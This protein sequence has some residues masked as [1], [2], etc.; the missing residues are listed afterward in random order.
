MAGSDY[1]ANFTALTLDGVFFFF[2]MT[3]IS[4]DAVLPLFLNRLGAS[5]IAIAAL[6]VAVVVGVN[7]P[8][9]F[10]AGHL[11]RLERKLPYV[12]TGGVAQRVPWMVAG[13]LVPFLAVDNPSV[14]TAAV[15]CAVLFSTMAA[16]LVIPGF[17]DIL[18][19]TIPVDRRGTLVALRSI[20]SY[21]AGI[22]GGF[23]VTTVL[24]NI[25]YPINY[26]V[27][28]GIATVLLFAGLY[29]MSRV[30][31]PHRAVEAGERRSVAQ[32]IRF[33]LG[34]SASFRWY[35]VM[36]SI[37]VISFATTG[38]FPVYLADSFGLS[39]SAAGLFTV[40]TAVTFVLVNPAFG[41]IG[42]RVGYKLLF[43]ISFAGLIGASVIG[44]TQAS[45]PTAYLLVV[46]ASISR[47]VN[48]LSFNMTVEF[49]PPGRVPSFIGV[50]GLFMGLI[51]PLALLLGIVV[52]HFGYSALFVVTA[53]TS[54]AGLAVL[55]F[56]VSEPRRA[57]APLTRPDI[58]A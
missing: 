39:D 25:R 37:L 46:L 28:F 58:P 49:A 22:G 26:T 11:E 51:A 56:G 3:F 52:D 57:T 36:R 9:I 27:L 21:L 2:G 14:V 18:T 42:N 10:A 50:S 20:L 15:I 41:R 17:F 43:G 47:A 6:P 4:V 40:I 1:R 33:V 13:L 30:R 23:I 34:S 54:A 16:G 38:F 8:S 24:A 44:I 35:V 32:R 7:L 48:L 12:I 55:I 45:L 29:S 53:V 31:E 19:A 5:N